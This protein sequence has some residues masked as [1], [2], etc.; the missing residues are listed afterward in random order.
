MSIPGQDV[1]RVPAPAELL[2]LASGLSKDGCRELTQSRA[3]PE[4]RQ[5]TLYA[6]EQVVS[7][8]PSVREFFQDKEA[9]KYFKID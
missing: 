6:Q 7:V 1:C 3:F 8:N 2:G 5:S 4:S 9:R